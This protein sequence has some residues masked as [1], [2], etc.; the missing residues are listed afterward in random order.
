MFTNCEGITIYEK[1]TGADSYPAYAV[2]HIK[3]VYWEEKRGQQLSKQQNKSTPTQ[4][5]DVY[6][7]IPADSITGY[8]PKYDD[9]VVKGLKS[10]TQSPS[11]KNKYT[12]MS[13]VDCLYGSKA[14]QH[15]EVTAV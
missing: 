10:I 5:Y 15:I 4:N 6:I 9:L 12:I 14:V 3:N 8:M 2:H 7:A 1:A 11:E 13:V